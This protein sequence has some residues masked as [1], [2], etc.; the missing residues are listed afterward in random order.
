MPQTFEPATP[1]ELATTSLP[2]FGSPQAAL[3]ALPKGVTERLLQL[4][5]HTQ[6]LHRVLPTWEERSQAR[7]ERILAVQR[8]GT[9]ASSPSR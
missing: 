8:A 5:E 7:D 3:G 1:A 4:R 2:L 9:D 6:N